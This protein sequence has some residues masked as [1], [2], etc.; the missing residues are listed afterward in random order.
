MVSPYMTLEYRPILHN[1]EVEQIVD[2]HGLIWDTNDRDAIPAHL[3]TAV[4]HAGGLLLGAWDGERPVGF[5]LAFPGLRENQLVLWSHATGILPE[6]QGRGIGSALKWLQRDHAIAQGFDCIRWTFDPLQRGNANFN[7]HRLGCVCNQYH[8]DF[9]GEITDGLN[10]GLPTDRFEVEWWLNSS[11][12]QAYATRM[13]RKRD[14]G[15]GS[16]DFVVLSTGEHGEPAQVAWPDAGCMRV[17]VEIPADINEL[18]H[19]AVHTA[20]NWR[21]TT[22]EVF[23]ELFA[24]GFVV[25]DIVR[26]ARSGDWQYSAYV[27]EAS[28]S[29]KNPVG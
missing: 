25:T 10:R 29:G 20:L 6:Y 3:M 9:Y 26:L 19:S 2:L 18:R 28:R 12:V 4:I 27:L 15:L 14:V 8:N 11:R 21:M 23:S 17:L 16:D 5:S 24:Q 13:I 1:H 22:R 7:I